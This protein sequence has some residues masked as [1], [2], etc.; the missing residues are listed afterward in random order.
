MMPALDFTQWYNV[1]T[2]P[3]SAVTTDSF[4]NVGT[5]YL[6][7]NIGAVA[8]ETYTVTIDQQ[9]GAGTC[10]AYLAA[11]Q[12]TD[13]P[14]SQ[15]GLEGGA[16]SFDLVAAG[17]WLTFRASVGNTTTVVSSLSVVPKEV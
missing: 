2:S 13:R 17:P 5:G 4:T 9:R 8:G 12:G 14:A 10:V 15:W 11:A 6:Q 3:M 7:L 16:E 1:P